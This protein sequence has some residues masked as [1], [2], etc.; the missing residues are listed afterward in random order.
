MCPAISGLVSRFY[1]GGIVD[2]DEVKEDNDT[3][4]SARAI[5]EKHYNFDNL[6]E[7]IAINVELSAAFSKEADINPPCYSSSS[8][9]ANPTKPRK[10][11][12]ERNAAKRPGP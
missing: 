11:N 1:K 6:S 12:R 5:S 3:R 10:F 8:T 2:S 7:V 9:I 4:K